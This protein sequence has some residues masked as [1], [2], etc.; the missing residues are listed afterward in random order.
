V[1]S[2]IISLQMKPSKQTFT[3]HTDAAG[4]YRFT[5][6]PPATYLLSAEAG[7]SGE[8]VI[9]AEGETKKCDLTLDYAF[10]DEPNFI[11]AGV[12]DPVSHGGHGSDSVMR[13]AEALANATASLKD[14]SPSN[15]P[16]ALEKQ[17]NALEAARKYQRAADL[18]AS[19]PNLFNWGTELLI[20]RAAEPATEVFAKGHRL[21]PR[22]LRMLLGLAAG[23]Y[24]RGD[25][26]RAAQSFFNACDLNPSDPVPYMF[27]GRVQSSEIT[28]LPDYLEMLARFAKLHPDNASANYD[29]AA[30]L[31]KQHKG[32][33]DTETPARV[34]ELLE[35]AIRL[36]P[37]LGVAYLQLGIVY[38]GQNDDAKAIAAYQEAIALSPQ[39]DEAHYRLGQAYARTGQKNKAR[40]ELDAYEQ[41]SK[42]LQREIELERSE[43]QQFVIELRSR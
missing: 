3:T 21:F 37:A 4:S 29:Y 6:L 38:S 36:D 16:A 40:Q 34:R 12:T 10:F 19:E 9:L 18:N 1:T 32:P 30:A 27:L 43:I 5:A 41:M 2:A 39:L 7:G 11:V 23:W 24:A 35:K 22:S 25:Y 42:K 28:K 13:S 17:G 20:H 26:E 33:E 8:T 31:W 15:G 14:E